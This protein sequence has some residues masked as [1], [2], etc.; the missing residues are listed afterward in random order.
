MSNL[1]LPKSSFIHIPKCAGT[2]LQNFLY[3]L[4]LPKYRYNE[5]QD[6]HLFLHQM[7]E[8]KDTYNFCFVRHPYTWWPSFYEWS[9][10]TRFSDMEKQSLNF[11]TWIKDYGAFWMGLYTQLVKR[12]IG[13]DPVYVS[14]IKM[15]FVGKTETLYSDLFT[16]LKNSKEVFDENKFQNLIKEADTRE[17]LIK[18]SNKQEYKREISKESKDVIYKTEKWMFDRFDYSR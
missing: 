4:E 5:P 8:S 11:D 17:S 9:K 13:E 1:L 12:Y 3:H 16:I 2:H 7:T 6:G 10:N 14:D 18:W 15:N